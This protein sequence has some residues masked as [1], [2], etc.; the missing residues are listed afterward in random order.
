MVLLVLLENYPLYHEKIFGVEPLK[1]PDE[2]FYVKND[3]TIIG[4]ISG[5][6]NFDGMFYIEFA[7]VFPEYQK[8]SYLRYIESALKRIGGGFI[9]AVN[10]ENFE[11]I[12]I[13]NAMKFIII[14]VRS[15][16]KKLFVE[17]MRG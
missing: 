16:D 2:V 10:H 7:G 9:T 6:R 1:I 3:H 8:G 13:L 15:V 17:F 14:G 11:S 5:H 4:F 12:K